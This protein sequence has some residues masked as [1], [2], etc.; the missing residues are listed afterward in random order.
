VT[1]VRHQRP[2]FRLVAPEAAWDEARAALD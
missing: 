1:F 2:E